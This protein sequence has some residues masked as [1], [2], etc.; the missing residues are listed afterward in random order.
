MP[1]LRSIVKSFLIAYPEGQA[2][3]A[4]N[5]LETPTL[6]LIGRSGAALLERGAVQARLARNGFPSNFGISDEFA[7]L[8]SFV[9]G[10]RALHA[11]AGASVANTDDHPIVAYLAPRITY[12]PDSSPPDRLIALL[13]ALTIA[14]AEL[15]SADTDPAFAR[16]LAAYWTAR[17]QFIAAGRAVRP[18]A[19]LQMMLAQVREPLLAVLRTSPDFR[20]AH[21]PLLRM[22]QALARSDAA[23]AQLLMRELA[24]ASE[25]RPLSSP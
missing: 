20:P 10:P 19:D 21:D 7:L 14:P 18:S 3:L 22:A 2:L 15:L 8:G 13:E 1:T 17:Q 6:G 23:A 11:F 24:T 9:A 25:S 4:S 16:R 5:S 12:A